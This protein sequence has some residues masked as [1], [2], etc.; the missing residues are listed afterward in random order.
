MS[1][2]T[3]TNDPEARLLELRMKIEKREEEITQ[4][5]AML[6]REAEHLEERRRELEAQAAALR[7]SADGKTAENMPV[8]GAQA[9][10]E[11]LL[12]DQKEHLEQ[13]RQLLEKQEQALSRKLADHNVARTLSM[14]CIAVAA[15]VFISFAGVY[16]SV[17]PEWRS[18]AIMQLSPPASVAEN[19]VPAWLIKQ[20]EAFHSD[21]VVG[22]AWQGLRQDGYA[23]HDRRESFAESL[24]RQMKTSRDAAARQISLQ[25][26]ALD[27]KDAA[28]IC[29]A[30]AGGYSVWLT[31]QQQAAGEQDG[32]AIDEPR[33]TLI[34]R[35]VP[36]HMPL[37]DDR[38]DLALAIAGGILAGA[39]I[40]GFIIRFFVRRS[41]RE[42]KRLTGEE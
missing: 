10:R 1:Q 41:L 36:A 28:D 19:D 42:I 14:V 40:L 8:G 18:E 9:A 12:A 5:L 38:R 37:K 31:R 11:K 4:H 26:T 23:G 32:H 39:T 3:Y 21:A 24:S 33:A 22:I 29:N 35:A 34:A 7:E 30:L 25:Y 2:N 13:L 6:G 17:K 27:P 20:E 15:I 16:H